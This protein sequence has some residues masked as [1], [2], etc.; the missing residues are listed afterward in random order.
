MYNVF[1]KLEENQVVKSTKATKHRIVKERDANSY[2]WK[3]QGLSIK[4]IGGDKNVYNTRTKSYDLK[5]SPLNLNKCY[6]AIED[7]EGNFLMGGTF[8]PAKIFDLMA[9]GFTVNGIDIKQAVE[10][11]GQHINEVIAQQKATG[12]YNQSN[13]KLD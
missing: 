11:Y 5:K 3:T 4:P 12:K 7:K 9:V 13:F 6:I 1:S 8:A 10:Q 2:K